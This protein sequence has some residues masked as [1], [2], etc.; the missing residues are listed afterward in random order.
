MILLSS[1]FIG[2]GYGTVQSNYL[3]IAIKEADSHRKA[4]ATSTFFIF[5]DLA[6]G[7]G[8]YIYGLLLGQ[9]SYRSVYS[10]TVIW[11]LLS[12]VVYFV[13]HGRKASIRQHLPL[14]N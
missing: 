8:P 12:I 13:F 1:V 11:I 10:L 9:M 7:V 4:T 5:M 2:I 14:E 3:A 6:I